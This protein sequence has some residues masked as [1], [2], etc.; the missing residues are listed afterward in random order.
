MV[1]VEWVGKEALIEEA[2]SIAGINVTVGRIDRERFTIIV[3][4]ET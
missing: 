4:G 3:G 2:F 1:D